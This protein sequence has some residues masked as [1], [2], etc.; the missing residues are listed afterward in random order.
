[1][2]GVNAELPPYQSRLQALRVAIGLLTP[3]YIF[4]AVQF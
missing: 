2:K 3:E 4:K 1:L